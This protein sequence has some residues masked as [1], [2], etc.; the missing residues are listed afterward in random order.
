MLSY[1]KGGGQ[2][3]TAAFTAIFWTL[4]IKDETP[5]EGFF[6]QWWA[7]G[8]FSIFVVLTLWT[9][10]TQLLRIRELENNRPKPQIELLPRHDS[11]CLSLTNNGESAIFKLQATFE[12]YHNCPNPPPNGNHTIE[13]DTQVDSTTLARH[14]TQEI[15]FIRTSIESG[16]KFTTTICPTTF[17]RRGNHFDP[18]SL[19]WV[20]GAE[21]SI[22][23][24]VVVVAIRVIASPGY[25][26]GEL[27]KRFRITAKGEVIEVT[28]P[29][30]QWFKKLPL[31]HIGL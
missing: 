19:Y 8:A 15:P 7:L 24:G 6:W 13:W 14:E 12:N 1:L 26:G 18:F 29:K 9:Q 27:T 10:I 23:I 28:T 2:V 30:K 25:V 5:N 16:T 22:P 31:I 4:D 20:A 17:F 11:Y 21:P 3:L